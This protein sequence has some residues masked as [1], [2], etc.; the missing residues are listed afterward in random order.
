MILISGPVISRLA[1]NDR[2]ISIGL[3]GEERDTL[4]S[5]LENASAIFEA[6][7][8]VERFSE[9]GHAEAALT[10]GDVDVVLVNS[11]ELVWHE[12]EGFFTTQIIQAA[13]TA[14]QQR[15]VLNE[16]GATAEQTA[17]LQGAKELSSRTIVEP[18]PDEQ[19][20]QVA[21]FLALIA[22]YISILVFGQFVAMGTV[23]EKQNRVV[24]VLLAKVQSTQVLVSKV[25]GIGLLG[26]GQ[27]GGARVGG[28]GDRLVR[29][30][31]H[32]ASI[33]RPRSHLGGTALVR[34]R[35]HAVR[36]RIRDVGSNR[37]APGRPPGCADGATLAPGA[38]LYRCSNCHRNA[39]W[40]S[41]A[42]RIAVP[43]LESDDHAVA[44]RNR[45]RIDSR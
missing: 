41:G 22:L 8:T 25:I 28:S 32:I 5:D 13:L 40:L 26:L 24:E 45:A 36:V 34:P 43:V 20:R 2:P 44:A 12:D 17:L 38:R 21:A 4:Q 27:P 3:V 10:D 7:I 23:Q 1:D 15:E 6:R 14:G 39:E 35:V 30:Q 18:G 16:L 11:R 37:L 33:P 19:A 31:R 29:R 42:L 9:L